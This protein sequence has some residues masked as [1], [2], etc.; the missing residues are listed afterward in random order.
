MRSP[1]VY[2]FSGQA[3]M[4]G[5]K[6]KRLRCGC[7]TIIDFRNKVRKK[8]DEKEIDSAMKGYYYES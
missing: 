7:C 2:N 8:E 1:A 5:K 3:N 6:E 4:K